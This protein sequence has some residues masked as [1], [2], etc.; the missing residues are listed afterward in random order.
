MAAAI[1]SGDLTGARRSLQYHCAHSRPPPS[2]GGTLHDR[3]ARGGEP[4]RGNF[5]ARSGGA[6]GSTYCSGSYRTA[7]KMAS[8]YSCSV[9]QAGRL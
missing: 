8:S 4:R 1:A 7:S 6:P 2:P 3:A 9:F 5:R